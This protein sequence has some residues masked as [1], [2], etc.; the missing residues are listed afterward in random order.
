[1][2]GRGAS[3]SSNSTMSYEQAIK[4]RESMPMSFEWNKV[5]DVFERKTVNGREATAVYSQSITK[6]LE[7]ISKQNETSV[8]VDYGSLNRAEKKL[9]GLGFKIAKR[10]PITKNLQKWSKVYLYIKK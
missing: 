2:G 6:G 3:S 1:M 5:M 9:E 7:T 10:T 4:M 8:I